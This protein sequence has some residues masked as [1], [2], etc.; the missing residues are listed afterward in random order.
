MRV[1]PRS[2]LK[3]RSETLRERHEQTDGDGDGDGD[4]NARSIDLGGGGELVVR[5]GW[6]ERRRMMMRMR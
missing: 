1:K 5:E 2:G 3:R 6:R 4:G